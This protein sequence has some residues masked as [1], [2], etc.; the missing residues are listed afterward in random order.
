MRIS[1]DACDAKEKSP[2][3]GDAPPARRAYDKPTVIDFGDVRE[4]TQGAGHTIVDFN[5]T[6]RQKA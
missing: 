3:N 4:L 2:L 6:P 1:M 5:G